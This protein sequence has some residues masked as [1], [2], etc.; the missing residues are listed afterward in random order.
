MAPNADGKA[1]STAVNIPEHA[2]KTLTVEEMYD[3]EKYDLTTM[4]EDDVFKMLE[5]V[6]TV[7]DRS[8]VGRRCSILAPNVRV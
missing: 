4:K 5:Y 7:D 1:K 8:L 3:K 2:V 6:A